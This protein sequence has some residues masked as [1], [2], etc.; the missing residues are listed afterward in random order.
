MPRP[1]VVVGVAVQGRAVV[2][3]GQPV[4]VFPAVVLPQAAASRTARPEVQRPDRALQQLLHQEQPADRRLRRQERRAGQRPGKDAKQAIQ[5]VPISASRSELRGQVN[6]L[7]EPGNGR[8]ELKPERTPE[9]AMRGAIMMIT[10]MTTMMMM[11]GMM[12]K[13]QLW[14]LVLQWWVG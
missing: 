8:N 1:V 13:L 5:N 4:V 10:T 9:R 2:V 6:G 12:E 14:R 3:R 7:S 11:T